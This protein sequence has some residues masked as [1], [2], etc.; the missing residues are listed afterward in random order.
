MKDS[1]LLTPQQTREFYNK[2][3]IK[4]DSQR[5][6][7]QTAIDDLIAHSNFIECHS[8]FEFG[9][10]TGRFAQEL[11][12]GCLPQDTIYVGH[13][14]SQTMVQ[15]TENKIRQFGD[16]A[17]VHL[18]DGSVKLEL[19]NYQFDRVVSMYVM[20]L[21]PF[22]RIELFL[23]EAQ[24]ILAA[25]GLLCLTGLTFGKTPLSGFVTWFWSRIH[26]FKPSLVGG[27]RP[28]H[29]AEILPEAHW[30]VVH[31]NVVTSWGISSEVLIAKKV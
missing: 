7:E 10:G 19:A 29:L 15:L 6:Y 2:F 23:N 3:G 31:S 28:V 27:C 14:I 5:F 8:I 18:I 24:R 22:D 26:R 16:R 21:L 12:S 17:K 4:Q 30:R 11:L 25:D 13:D 9:C 20:D 1:H